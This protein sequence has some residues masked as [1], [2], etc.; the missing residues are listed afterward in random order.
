M[1]NAVLLGLSRQMALGR[2]LDVIANNVANVSTTG[3]KAR[4]ARFREHLGSVGAAS[5]LRPGD[6]RISFTADAGTPIDLAPGAVERTG[7]ALDLAVKG[8]AFFTVA[9]PGGERYTRN[10][11][12]Q[13]DAKGTLVTSDGHAV[14]GER[15]PISIGPQERGLA[16]G[17]DGTISTD[18]GP[19]GKIRLVRFESPQSLASEGA[20][21]YAASTPALAADPAARVESGALERSNVRPVIEMTRLVEVTRAYTEQAALVARLDDLKR[22]AISRLADAA[23][24]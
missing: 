7:G 19:R 20:N 11:A 1:E 22:N 10:G 4:S 12:F 5:G 2:E 8:D 14:L 23:A 3:F 15:G 17:P 6:G 24:N 16:V 13:L 9:T 21:L 18:Q